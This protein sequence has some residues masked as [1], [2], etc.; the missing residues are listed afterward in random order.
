MVNLNKLEYK[1]KELI[2][3]FSEEELKQY[4][5]VLAK[6]YYVHFL[7]NEKELYN[8]TVN[9]LKEVLQVYK[10]KY[11][12][13]NNYINFCLLEAINNLLNETIASGIELNSIDKSED[14]FSENPFQDLINAFYESKKLYFNDVEMEQKIKKLEQENKH[15]KEQLNNG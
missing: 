4:I 6:K 1:R 2:S 10:S 5:Q 3:D 13:L 11:S 7:N 12:N 9:Q 15:L 14:Y 8:N